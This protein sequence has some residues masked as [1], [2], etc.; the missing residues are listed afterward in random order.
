[1]VALADYNWQQ[2]QQYDITVAQPSTCFYLYLG[3]NDIRTFYSGAAAVTRSPVTYKGTLVDLMVA[4]FTPKPR[5]PQ[6]I[7][8]TCTFPEEVRRID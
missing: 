6:E 5:G 1:M 4:A 8:F 3:P 2:S 7:V